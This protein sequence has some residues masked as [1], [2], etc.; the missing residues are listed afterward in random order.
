MVPVVRGEQ[1]T[2]NR[3]PTTRCT[4]LRAS[5]AGRP[6][7]SRSPAAGERERSAHYKEATLAGSFMTR[8][9]G[10]PISHAATAGFLLGAVQAVYFAHQARGLLGTDASAFAVVVLRVGLVGFVVGTPA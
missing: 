5:G 8:T 1:L 7:A 4:C 6:S 9:M 10:T 2:V 3:G